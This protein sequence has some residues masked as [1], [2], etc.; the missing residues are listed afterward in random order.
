MD[1]KYH[2]TSKS[3]LRLAYDSLGKPLKRPIAVFL[4]TDDAGES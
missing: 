1:A 2:D 3:P 4:I